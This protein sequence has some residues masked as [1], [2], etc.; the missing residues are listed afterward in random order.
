MEGKEH[1]GVIDLELLALSVVLFVLG[2]FTGIMILS[3][4]IEWIEHGAN[5]GNR[6]RTRL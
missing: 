1:A 2:L 4:I 5:R 3:D 6:P